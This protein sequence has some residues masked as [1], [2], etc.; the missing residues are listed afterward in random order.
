MISGSV[1]K[2]GKELSAKILQD[3]ATRFCIPGGGG[4][5][6][7]FNIF[8]QCRKYN[9]PLLRCPQFLF[10]LM[11]LF[12]DVV[13]IFF[14]FIGKN[15][16]GSPYAISLIIILITI[17]LLFI[18]F[19]IIQGFEKLAEANSIKE[20]FISIISHKLRTPIT[21]LKWALELLTENKKS[22]EE[23]KEYFHILGDNCEIMNDLISDLLTVSMLDSGKFFFK[24]EKVATEKFVADIVESFKTPVDSLN[25]KMEFRAQKG[26][27]KIF[28]DPLKIELAIKNIINNA[29]CYRKSDG[30]FKKE[31]SYIIIKLEKKNRQVYL[32]VK[33]NGMG[34][35]DYEKKYIFEKLFRSGDKLK[36]KS[37]RSGLELYVSKAIIEKSG[38]KIGFKSQE[39]FGSTFWVTL[40]IK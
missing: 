22:D 40:P 4:F 3:G 35:P 23:L 27:P 24:K 6:G 13:I 2:N 19:V 36:N 5:W 20:E 28:I 29:V 18:S 16:I 7:Q 37:E 38:G 12:I 25:I 10:C 1:K 9:L 32:E 11:G 21:S 26:L 15:Y 31:Q 17:T 8:S 33:D 34:I 39:G 14:Y 30:D